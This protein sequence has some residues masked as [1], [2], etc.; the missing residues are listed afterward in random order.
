MFDKNIIEGC[1]EPMETISGL[2]LEIVNGE[3]G[4]GVPSPPVMET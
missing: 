2:P 3:P 4:M 1:L